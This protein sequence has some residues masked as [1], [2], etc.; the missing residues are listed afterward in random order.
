LFFT[1][2]TDY[3]QALANKLS[4]VVTRLE[5]VVADKKQLQDI[6][7]INDILLDFS[8]V[9]CLTTHRQLANDENFKCQIARHELNNEH[10]AED[11]PIDVVNLSTH[12]GN[13]FI[14]STT[15]DKLFINTANNEPNQWILVTFTILPYEIR[16]FMPY[17]CRNYIGLD[18]AS[19]SSAVRC[20][21]GNIEIIPWDDYNRLTKDERVGLKLEYI[22]RQVFSTKSFFNIN[23]CLNVARDLL[24]DVTTTFK[25]VFRRFK[26]QELN[27]IM[28]TSQK[29]EYDAMQKS[30]F[31]ASGRGVHDY[32]LR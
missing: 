28:T 14:E 16:E 8:R 15:A 24:N 29:A 7:T 25:P 20:V 12:T 26:I 5:S 6:T 31:E 22:P 21:E 23:R 13:Y 4:S 30:K 1:L 18:F 9:L 17:Y 11:F 32:S 3:E 27:R 2:D 10:K 19:E